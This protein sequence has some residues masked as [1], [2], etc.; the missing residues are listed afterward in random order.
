[1]YVT[2]GNKSFRQERKII[3]I[4]LTPNKNMLLI[5]IKPRPTILPQINKMACVNEGMYMYLCQNS[6]RISYNL[7]IAI[8]SYCN[9]LKL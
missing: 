6:R 4:N 7:T 8:Y 2:R 3:P 5:K 9:L 1:M